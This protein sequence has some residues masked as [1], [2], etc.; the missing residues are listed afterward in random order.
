MMEV[1][2]GM[3]FLLCETLPTPEPQ[4]GDLNLMHHL[5]PL[6]LSLDIETSQ[7][8]RKGKGS[9][10]DHVK[11][12][13]NAFMVWS[14]IERKKM[15]DSYPDMHNAEIS[16]RL[17]KR[18]KTLSDAD[19]RPFVIRSEKLREEHMRR[20]PD[21]KYRPKKKAKEAEKTNNNQ[22]QPQQQQQNQQLK[23]TAKNNINNNINNDGIIKLGP[24]TT[25]AYSS[26][27]IGNAKQL[28]QPIKQASIT[29]NNIATLTK[30]EGAKLVNIKNGQCVM[31]SGKPFLT[32]SRQVGKIGSLS[33]SEGNFSISPQKN[34]LLKTTSVASGQKMFRANPLT[35]PP[36]VPESS[37]SP[38]DLE[39]NLSFYD[40]IIDALDNKKPRCD[41]SS[42]AEFQMAP[43]WTQSDSSDSGV[44]IPVSPLS[45]IATSYDFANIYTTPEVSE[46]LS[47]QWIDSSLGF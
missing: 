43:I 44:D 28:L 10:Q 40:D 15:A 7:R 2:V 16:R 14:K 29:N 3:D 21:Y 8:K 22:Q 32:L 33:S 39:G 5:N 6:E 46:L 42:S 31:P 36:N 26:V 12:P 47:S 25:I 41:S 45:D 23:A 20:Y 13:M 19:R 9:S 4:D 1:D 34:C 17:G 11:R 24:T 30:L 18:W 35:P 37:L 27:P 38:I